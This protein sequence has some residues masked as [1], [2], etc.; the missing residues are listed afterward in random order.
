MRARQRESP[1]LKIGNVEQIRQREIAV[2]P[3]AWIEIE[4]QRRDDRHRRQRTGHLPRRADRQERPCEQ[5]E[6]GDDHLGA[7]AGERHRQALPAL[8]QPPCVGRVRIEH[9][10]AQHQRDAHARHATAKP[11]GDDRVTH[12]VHAFERDEQRGVGRQGFGRESRRRARS[13]GV[14]LAQDEEQREQHRAAEGKPEPTRHDEVEGRRDA[15]QHP[16][17]IEKRDAEE[18]IVMRDLEREIAMPRLRLLRREAF[19]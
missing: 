7:D 14:P 16:V 5:G 6:A 4:R 2:E 8:R 19:P 9:R 10:R 1:V 17:G 12:L 3:H 11:L 15:L 18:K 13:E